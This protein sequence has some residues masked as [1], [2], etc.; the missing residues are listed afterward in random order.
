M[1]ESFLLWADGMGAGL[2]PCGR[3]LPDSEPQAEVLIG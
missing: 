3:S 2:C 1:E